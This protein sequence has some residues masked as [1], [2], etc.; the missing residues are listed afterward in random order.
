MEVFIMLFKKNNSLFKRA[1]NE[2]K[3]IDRE[4]N[5]M[6]QR[7]EKKSKEIRSSIQEKSAEFKQRKEKR[8]AM[9][10]SIRSKQR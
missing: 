4:Y 5:E 8:R 6:A 1:L 9:F 2:I 3:E 10:N 7:N